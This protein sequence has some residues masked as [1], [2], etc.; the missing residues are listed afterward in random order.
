MPT[1]F[2]LHPLQLDRNPLTSIFDGGIGKLP[3]FDA[4]MFYDG[5]VKGIKL[6]TGIDLSSPQALFESIADLVAGAFDPANVIALLV[7]V[8]GYA[9]APVAT[10][11]ALARWVGAHM[12]GPIGAFRLPQ[13]SLGSITENSPNLLTRSSFAGEDAINDPG[14]RWTSDTAVFHTAGGA[15]A[16][17]TCNGTAANLLSLDLIPVSEGQKVT[18]SGWIK[19]DSVVGTAASVA[20]GVTTYSDTTGSAVVSQPTVAVVTDPSGSGD[21][22]KISGTY[23]AAA[24]VMSLRVRLVVTSGATAGTVWFDDLAAV[25]ANVFKQSFVDGLV[26]VLTGVW[27]SIAD[28]VAD[29]GDKL[30]LDSFNSWISSTFNNLHNV[31]TGGFKSIFDAWFGGNSGTGTAAEVQQ[32]VEAIKDAV[33]NGYTVTTFTSSQANWAVPA[34]TE[35]IAILVGGGQNGQGGTNGGSTVGRL[36]G[37]SGSYIAQQIDLT[38]I[39]A[40]DIAV[41][42]AG[43]K[44]FVRQANTTTPHSGTVIIASPTHGSIG[45]IST[46]LG[47]TSTTSTPGKGG[48]GGGMG[49]GRDL[50]Q[51]GE[52]SAVVAGGAP[53]GNNGTWGTPGQPGGSVSAGALTKCGGGGGGGGGA[54]VQALNVGGAGGDGGYPGGGGGAGGNCSGTPNQVGAGG[55]G[56]LGVVWLFYR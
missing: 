41:G 24:G 4:K 18:V 10:I 30:S 33:I 44:S 23:T 20:L 50:P 7:K 54:A 47:Y 25:N 8:F 56:A 51:A 17:I 38:G 52:S 3:G 34:H 27:D 49:T 22:A 43:N 9:A 55:A 21:W 32:T 29:I 1:A 40:L 6:I 28:A 36:G 37:Y 31:V 42:T 15:A 53:G 35:C 13:I 2:D 48:K 12:F 39:T 14:G 16:R 5:F 46:A 11:E 19:R 26:G 45:G